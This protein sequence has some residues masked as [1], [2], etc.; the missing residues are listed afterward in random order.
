MLYQKQIPKKKSITRCRFN[1]PAASEKRTAFPPA[2]IV[3]IAV[4]GVFMILLIAMCIVLVNGYREKKRLDRYEQEYYS[5]DK[6]NSRVR[7]N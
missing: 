5:L 6:Y 4:G 2:G 1:F 7:N 3:G